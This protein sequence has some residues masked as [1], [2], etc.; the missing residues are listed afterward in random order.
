MVSIYII[1]V[2]THV[3]QHNTFRIILFIILFL[4]LCG[5]LTHGL[6]LILFCV[7][8]GHCVWTI[9]K[10]YI[11]IPESKTNIL[12]VK[13][14]PQSIFHTKYIN[15]SRHENVTLKRFF[16]GNYPKGGE[17]LYKVFSYSVLYSFNGS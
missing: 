7:N 17:G 10:V 6:Q 13:L 16:Y 1:V 8:P 12:I 5:N 4:F 15:A 14:N 9:K 2:N 11:F 3:Q